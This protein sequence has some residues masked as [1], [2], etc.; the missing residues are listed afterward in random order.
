MQDLFD[1]VHRFDPT[2]E[3]GVKEY[4]FSLENG[5]AALAPYF[6]PVDM[7]RYA[8]SLVVTEAGPLVAYV[9]SMSGAYDS[10]L[11]ARAAEFDDFVRA[12][13]ARQGAIR[14]RKDAGLFIARK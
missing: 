5:A 10:S 7:E 4:P 1:L 14:I 6:W 13:I 2:L 12:E 8:D 9:L 11:P 3:Y